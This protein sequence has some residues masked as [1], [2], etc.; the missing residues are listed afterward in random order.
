MI[1][2]ST[3]K[4]T[5]NHLKRN[6]YLYV[7]QSTMKQVLEHQESTKR[8]YAL[9]QKAKELGWP[10]DSIIVID[11]DLGASQAHQQMAERVSNDLWL[12]LVSGRLV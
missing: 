5:K 10:F 4:V 3:Q 2:Q 1:M 9:R 12:K 11:D 6:A 7:R 8:Q